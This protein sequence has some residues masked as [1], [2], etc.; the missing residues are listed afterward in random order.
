MTAVAP[1]LFSSW[2]AAWS[3]T[4]E[5]AERA[6]LPKQSPYLTLMPLLICSA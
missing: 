2:P 1:C 3:L 4:V 5:Q 6:C